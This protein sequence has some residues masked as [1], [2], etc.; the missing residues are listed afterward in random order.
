ML[1]GSKGIDC[2]S[3]DSYI[4]SFPALTQQRLKEMRDIITGIIPEASETISYEMPAYRTAKGKVIVYFGGFNNH[5][6][7]FPTASGVAAFQS[8]LAAYKTSKGTIRF[9]LSEP[10]PEC[11]ITKIVAFRRDEVN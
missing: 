1:K 5:I 3:V 11:L 10:L 2:S 4:A 9:S 8:E 6:A 7:L